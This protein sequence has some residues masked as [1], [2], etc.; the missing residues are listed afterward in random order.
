MGW[1]A[2]ADLEGRGWQIGAV[3]KGPHRCPSCSRRRERKPHFRRVRTERFADTPSGQGGALP[4]LIVV[5]AAKCGTTSLHYYLGLHPEVCMS[6]PKQLNFFQDPSCLDR[7]DLYA[8]FFDKRSPVRGESTPLYSLYPVIPG[9]PERISAALPDV[10]LI[11]LVREPVERAI[12]D[13]IEDLQ[14]DKERRTLE[15]AF[16]DV[17]DPYNLHVA[18]SRYAT[19]IERFLACI[20]PDDLLVVDQADLRDR[21]SETLQEIFRFIGVD[22]GFTTRDFDRRLNPT[23]DKRLRSALG[24][25]LR[26]TAPVRAVVRLPPGFVDVL[27][28]P[29]RHVLSERLEIPSA[30][31]RLRERLVHSLENEVSRFRELTGKPF[32][33]WCA[34]SSGAQKR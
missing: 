10:K 25:R 3:D 32:A 30:D 13:Y 21:R 8:S 18:G 1:G 15:E 26:Q 19:Q 34:F 20:S 6:T 28:R 27:L 5:G 4:N 12:A 14:H 31:S 7:L 29:V 11:Y 2:I 17:Y 16:H 33:D 24:R 23:G 9:V 22:D